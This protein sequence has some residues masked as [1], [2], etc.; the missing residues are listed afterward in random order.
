VNQR[1]KRR[2]YSL[3]STRKFPGGEKRAERKKRPSAREVK[4]KMKGENHSLNE[5]IQ[6]PSR[7]RKG[8]SIKEK[9]RITL[10]CPLRRRNRNPHFFEEQKNGGLIPSKKRFDCRAIDIA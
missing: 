4:K 3:K 5:K 8:H 7:S 6:R 10:H 1:K 2:A 9:E